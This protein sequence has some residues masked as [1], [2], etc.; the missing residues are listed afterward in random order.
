[1]AQKDKVLDDEEILQQINDKLPA[2]VCKAHPFM[3]L[4][5]Q[6]VSQGINQL[7][8]RLD[9]IEE[10]VTGKKTI[11][12]VWNAWKDRIYGFLFAVILML[13]SKYFHF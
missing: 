7:N 8:K 1:M 2:D 9:P 11:E 3:L 13:V 5:I 6:K 10:Y 12:R 4:Y